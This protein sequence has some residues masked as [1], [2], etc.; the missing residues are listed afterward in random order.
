MAGAGVTRLKAIDDGLELRSEDPQALAQLRTEASARNPEAQFALGEVYEH[1]DGDAVNWYDEA[2]EWYR[3]AADQ[4][5]ADAQLRRGDLYQ[6]RA[7][8]SAD[9][10]AN[11]AWYY[12][13]ALQ[14]H[15]EDS[16]LD[17]AISFA[18]ANRS[19]VNVDGC[20]TVW[21]KNGSRLLAAARVADAVSGPC[22]GLRRTLSGVRRDSA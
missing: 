7:L 12:R 17:C 2:V 16:A 20:P 15:V 9:D 19:E 5:H 21:Q 1:M 13:A 4:G 6:Y 3:K 10:V 11:M 18:A 14:G 8:G 22:G